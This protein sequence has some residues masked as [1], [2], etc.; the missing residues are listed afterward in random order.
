MKK[1]LALTLALALILSVCATASAAT[2]LRLNSRGTLVKRVQQFLNDNGYA[3]LKVDGV[4]GE[5]TFAA[6]AI[7]QQM[8][9]L[10][11]DG[12]AGPHT[13]EKMFG[14]KT[15]ENNPNADNR[16][17]VG[18]TGPTVRHIQERL[19]YY[20]FS[21]AVDG[22]FGAK[23]RAQVIAFQKANSLQADGIVGEK[24]MAILESDTAES[25]K[26]V[27]KYPTLRRGMAGKD[28]ITLQQALATLGLY[29]EVVTGYYNAATQEAVVNF[30]RATGLKEDGVAGPITLST[31]YGE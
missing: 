11:A 30:Q 27:K 7:Y 5:A 14:T 26:V 2:V 24:T 17:T 25:Y 6:V 4:Y 16:Y 31:L 13:F 19:C 22:T 28:V 29:N 3:E 1:L 20:G 10:V 23:T 21:T 12:K 9:S 8:N 15:P 18:S